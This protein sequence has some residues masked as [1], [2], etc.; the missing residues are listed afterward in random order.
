MQGWRVAIASLAKPDA[1]PQGAA[2]IFRF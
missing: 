2:I 1:V